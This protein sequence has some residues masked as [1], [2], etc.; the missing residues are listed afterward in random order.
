MTIAIVLFV[1]NQILKKDDGNN[2]KED[3]DSYRFFHNKVR[4]N[5]KMTTI[6]LLS[7]S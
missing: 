4:I 6:M 5:K 3:D 7:S 1:A 2:V